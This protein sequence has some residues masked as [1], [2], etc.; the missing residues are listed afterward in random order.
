MTQNIAAH[1]FPVVLAKY[2]EGRKL[3]T[4]H[5]TCESL[6][7]FNSLIAFNGCS[8]SKVF[9]HGIY[10]TMRLNGLSPKRSYLTTYVWDKLE[11]VW[12]TITVTDTNDVPSRYIRHDFPVYIRKMLLDEIW[13]I[14][15]GIYELVISLKG[16][17][18]KLCV[19]TLDE[20]IDLNIECFKLDKLVKNQ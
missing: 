9:Y 4:E 5:G 18:K 2:E 17:C 14:H 6:L 20:N 13:N 1:A 11:K 12:L 15:V 16:T 3:S 7:S 8:I 19:L 10:G